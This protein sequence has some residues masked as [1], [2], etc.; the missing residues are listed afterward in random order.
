M[1]IRVN[2]V[3]AKKSSEISSNSNSN[4]K[5]DPVWKSIGTGL[6][7][8]NWELLLECLYILVASAGR[9]NSLI[10][11]LSKLIRSSQIRTTALQRRPGIRILNFQVT[12]PSLPRRQAQTTRWNTPIARDMQT[13]SRS[14]VVETV[15]CFLFSHRECFDDLY[16]RSWGVYDD[17]F[18][19]VALYNKKSSII[20]RSSI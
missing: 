8:F 14:I 13:N 3:N 20:K 4:S 1:L 19:L 11:N 7:W 2:V 5:L 18:T 12:R 6:V 9:S 15:S 16:S 10:N 17:H